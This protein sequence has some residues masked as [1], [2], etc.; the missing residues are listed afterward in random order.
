MMN[1][2]S[3]L[4][5]LLSMLVHTSV[6]YA[7]KPDR[8]SQQTAKGKDRDAPVI[9]VPDNLI[10]E[11][12][13]SNG[14]I[15]TYEVTATDN[16][17]Q[18][19]SLTCSPV[20][21]SI[22]SLGTSQVAC[23]ATDWKGN[24]SSSSFE[25]SVID[26]TA[27]VL[28]LPTDISLITASEKETTVNYEVI[29]HDAVAGNLAANCNPVSGSAFPVGETRVDCL[30][31]DHHG[32]SS[33]GSFMVF[34]QFGA[35]Q[36]PPALSIPGD[37]TVE[38]DSAEGTL[39]TYEVSA[40]DDFDGEVP[41]TC[42]HASGTLF[43]LGQTLVTCDAADNQGNTSSASFNVTVADTQPPVLE[44]PNNI[45]HTTTDEGMNVPF[46]VNATDRVD[47]DVE[48]TCN[49]NSGSWFSLG[50]TS[51]TCI[52]S[53]NFNNQSSGQFLVTLLAEVDHTS[54]SGSFT[55]TWDAP[56][57]RDN[58][59]PLLQDELYAYRIRVLSADG[60]WD[61]EI[62]TYDVADTSYVWT[63]PGS[64]SYEISVSAL[65]IFGFESAPSNSI[66]G[67]V[68]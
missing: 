13:D 43:P 39:V 8:G 3:L 19:V 42:S 25:V 2:F 57:Y 24:S 20:S 5:L 12:S 16:V 47:P 54:D 1:R 52:A 33:A 51:V 17:D 30:A 53:D 46:S 56:L 65:D 32:N 64:G 11:A 18:N 15:V 21:G 55:F 34:V 59:E 62:V 63:S 7:A 41:P 44:I 10:H 6:T 29:A 37:M 23:V 40:F 35:D 67:V 36:S 49:P 68:P 31:T 22:F 14:A 27:P 28:A 9:T 60:S 58:G 48:I 66:T 4:M 26:S 45:L 50:E 38:A 61:E